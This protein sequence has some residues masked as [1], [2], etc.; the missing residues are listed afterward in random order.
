MQTCIHRGPCIAQEMLTRSYKSV[1]M[2][3]KEGSA[4]KCIHWNGP[5]LPSRVREDALERSSK[6]ALSPA[7]RSKDVHLQIFTRS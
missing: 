1:D 2:R 4:Q 7:K 5:L 6:K 3:M